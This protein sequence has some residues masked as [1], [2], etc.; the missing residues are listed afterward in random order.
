M[1]KKLGGW[2]RLWFSISFLYGLAIIFIAVVNLPKIENIPYDASHLKLL[3]DSTLEIIAG[4]EIRPVGLPE[5]AKPLLK[6]LEMPN[7]AKITV[8]VNTNEKQ[9]QQVTKDYIN[10][11][12]KIAA[13][14]K[15]S[16]I[17]QYFLG[18]FI[19]CLSTL[20]LGFLSQWIYRGFK[21]E[22]TN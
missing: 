14:K 6:E 20:L 2:W 22:R 10:V 7:G 13:E 5:W 11:L 15:L 12:K 8:P 16:A 9:S 19:P 17:I 21:A 18:W 4:K 1:T 3:H